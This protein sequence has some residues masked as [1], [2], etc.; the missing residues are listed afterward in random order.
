LKH[1]RSRERIDEEALQFGL[2][3][4]KTFTF[5]DPSQPPPAP[6]PVRGAAQPLP[7]ATTGSTPA[8]MGFNPWG[9][10][11]EESGSFP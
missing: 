6:V 7:F 2:E 3:E 10:T 4:L 8:G 9:S 1:M 5:Y 11:F